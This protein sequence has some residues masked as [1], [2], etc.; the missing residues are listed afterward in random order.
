MA[1]NKRTGVQP[2]V[3]EAKLHAKA[4]RLQSAIAGRTR[5]RVLVAC[6]GKSFPTWPTAE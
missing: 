3:Y 4:E 1:R 2:S 5:L 6:F